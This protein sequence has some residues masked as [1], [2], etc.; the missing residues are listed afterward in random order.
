M[1]FIIILLVGL[2]IGSFLNVCIDRIPRGECIVYPPSHCEYCG[3]RLKLLNLIPVISFCLLRGKCRYCQA[4]LSRRYPGIELLT[5]LS[6]LFVYF[7]TLWGMKLLP[8]LTL[9]SI[10]LVI[11]FIDLDCFRIPN[12]IIITGL[13]LGI[14]FNTFFPFIYW[15]DALIGFMTG[16]GILFLIALASRGGMG[17]GDI[18]LGAMIGFYLGWQQVLLAIFMGALFASIVSVF[19]II[20]KKKSQ[21]DAIPFGPFLSLGT[22]IS[23]IFGKNIISW[24][25]TRFF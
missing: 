10:L 20:G 24:Y 25:V 4:T 12:S 22:L 23:I 9:T 6:F 19:L 1:E 18:K 3:T 13:L 7:F 21:K 16:G 15:F 8:Y 14:G 17:G 2:I 11:S 5:G